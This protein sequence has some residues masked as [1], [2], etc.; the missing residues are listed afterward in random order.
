[1]AA[2]FT[3]RPETVWMAVFTFVLA[4]V[5]IGTLAVLRNQ[6]AEMHGSGE[7]TDKIIAAAS[8]IESHQKQIVSDNKQILSDN[9]SALAESLAENR[10][11]IDLT[12]QQS[13]QAFETSERDIKRVLDASIEASRLDQRAW[14]GVIEVASP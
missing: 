3:A 1:M 12:I 4:M 6:L 14:V 5:G 13:R 11:E 8:L 10:R 9:R 2:A 7:Q